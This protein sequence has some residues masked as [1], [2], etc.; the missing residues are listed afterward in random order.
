MRFSRQ[1]LILQIGVVVLLLA[2][3]LALVSWLLWGTLRDQYGE[4]ALGIARSVAVD[5]VVVTN[6]TDKRPGGPLEDLAQAVTRR[7]GA[8]FVVITDDKGIRLAHPNPGEIGKPVS[9]PAV[10]ALAG[11]DVVS[12]VQK[13]TLGVSVR[14]KTPIFAADGRVVGEVSVG[15]EI[16]E[17]TGDLIRLILTSALFAAGALALGV[18][19]S[20]LLTRRLNRLTHGLEPRELTELL[21]EREAVLHGIGEGMLAVD[22]GGRV[23][24]RNA[25]AERLLGKPLPVGV[26]VSE[27]GLS[28]RLGKAVADHQPVDNLLAVAGNRVLVVN[29]RAVQRDDRDLGMVLTFRDRTDL[30]TLTREL[31]A[32]RSLSDGLRAQRHEFSNRLHTLSGLLQLGHNGEAV[33]YLQTLTD[34]SISSPGA[35]GDSVTDPY[36]QALL[37][38]KIEQAQEKGVR[39]R[40]SD[41]SWVRAPVTDPITVNTVVGNLLDNALHAARLGRL[42][43]FVEIALLAEGTTLHVSVVDSGSGVAAEV[44]EKLFDEGV[45]T[46]ISPGHGLGLALARQAARAHGGDVW[47]ADPG[48]EDRGALFVA[49]L[50]D[51]LEA[52][53]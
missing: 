6:V 30:D 38:A 39:L 40:L 35:L 49:A 2:V 41:D 36:L 42:P 43:A 27:L 4:R 12:A 33:E 15:Y 24:V 20:A 1:I 45:S 14:S 34:T 51:L 31:D 32:V 11:N 25:E 48:G 53:E 50:P 29:S 23:S 21:Y 5:P 22:A 37:A 8:L 10:E 18:A 13:G 47:L 44:R 28:P 16:G 52:Q 17:A 26:P 19:A 46:K 7:T 3:G 9:T